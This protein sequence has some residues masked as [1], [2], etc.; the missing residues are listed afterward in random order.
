MG[1]IFK[2]FGQGLLYILVLPIFLFAIAL[3]GVY[4]V[5]LFV[6]LMIKSIICFFQG[7]SLYKD[8]P[9][10]LEAKRIL[11]PE[12]V[13]PKVETI[14]EERAETVVIDR[15]SEERRTG[16]EESRSH[17]SLTESRREGLPLREDDDDL[18][19][20]ESESSDKGGE[21]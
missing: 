14:I 17:G 7:K 20:D 2:K 3:F 16:I 18:I 10:D 19:F 4:G 9:E 13:K 15:G 12:T 11:H 6:F 21:E 5:G 8:L 1:S